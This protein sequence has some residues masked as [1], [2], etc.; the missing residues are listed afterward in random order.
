MTERIVEIARLM[1]FMPECECGHLKH[2]HRVSIG[3]TAVADG[4]HCPCKDYVE[5]P[6]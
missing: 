2:T 1:R 3:C 4:L 6:K 5:K